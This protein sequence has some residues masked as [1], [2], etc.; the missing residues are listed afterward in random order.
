METFALTHGFTTLQLPLES[1]R[2]VVTTHQK[3][4]KVFSYSDLR[5]RGSEMIG[6]HKSSAARFAGALIL[7]FAMLAWTGCGGG[8]SGSSSGASSNGVTVTPSSAT[9]RVGGATQFSANVTGNTNQSV[10]WT[11][12]GI[13]NGNTT[14]GAIDNTGKYTAPLTLPTSIR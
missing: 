3:Q 9:L 14:V 5:E 13:A 11:V 7:F 8:L 10:T 6:P 1:L 4:I 12:N 2:R